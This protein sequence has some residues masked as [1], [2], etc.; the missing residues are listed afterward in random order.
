MEQYTSAKR[1]IVAVVHDGINKLRER[2]VNLDDLVYSVQLYY[3]PTERASKTKIM[4][5]PYQ[6]ALQLIDAGEKLSRR[7]TV[8]FIKVKPFNY[9]G[10]TFTVK[11]VSHVKSLAEINVEDYVRNLRTAL[12]Q[13][14]ES[15]DIKLER[16]MK[17]TDWFGS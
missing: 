3:D 14:F 1:K 13:T 5:Q 7:D 17:L 9:K 15:M 2:E 16:D 10:R 8:H 6:C 11:P 4:P 12:E